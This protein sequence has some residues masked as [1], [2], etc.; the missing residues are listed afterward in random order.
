MLETRF[1][2]LSAVQFILGIRQINIDFSNDGQNVGLRTYKVF[3]ET[4]LVN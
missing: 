4:A 1:S 3:S 2:A